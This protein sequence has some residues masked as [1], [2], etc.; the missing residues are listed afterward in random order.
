[1]PAA[2]SG[3]DWQLT[4]WPL[5][6]VVWRGVGERIW[7]LPLLC[8]L[9]LSAAHCVALSLSASRALPLS[10][11]LCFAPIHT[12]T[13]RPSCWWCC[14]NRLIGNYGRG[15]GAVFFLPPSVGWPFPSLWSSS[16]STLLGW[17]LHCL[18]S[19]EGSTTL[20]KKGF[21]RWRDYMFI[22]LYSTMWLPVKASF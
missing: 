13:H 7:S 12:H 20:K 21:L 14:L 5:L 10:L 9:S 6:P 17:S 2:T 1:M 11:T 15:T 8:S 19:N 18:Y 16:L 3:F 4:A 22:K